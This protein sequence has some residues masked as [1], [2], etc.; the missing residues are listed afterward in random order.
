M[1]YN[2]QIHLIMSI[3]LWQVIERI[4]LAPICCRFLVKI[5]QNCIE[6]LKRRYTFKLGPKN[7]LR[8]N[9]VKQLFFHDFSRNCIFI[10][11][12]N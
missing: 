9:E 12:S 11:N 4:Q 3:N 2:K 5:S 8:S 6:N 7:L 10:E 1:S